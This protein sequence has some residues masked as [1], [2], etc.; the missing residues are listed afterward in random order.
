MKG[1][2]I[3]ALG[4]IALW[5]RWLRL[6]FSTGR[7]EK[8]KQTD[9]GNKPFHNHTP[10]KKAHPEGCAE[11]VFPSVS[12]P[13]YTDKY[14]HKRN[15]RRTPFTK[16]VF[17]LVDIDIY[18]ILKCSVVCTHTITINPKCKAGKEK[19]YKEFS[20]IRGRFTDLFCCKMQ[21]PE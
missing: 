3:Y 15:K 6:S 9:N 17:L 13:H 10:S 18:R 19:R 2:F 20:R 4:I 1:Q 5:N 21:Q 7:K 8:C 16:V 11:K 12:L 14:T